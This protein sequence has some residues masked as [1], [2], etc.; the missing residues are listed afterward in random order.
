M[1]CPLAYW[2][3]MIIL[4]GHVQEVNQF[5]CMRPV[6]IHELLIVSEELDPAQSCLFFTVAQEILHVTYIL[7]T[8][9]VLRYL[10]KS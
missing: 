3:C 1:Q 9:N 8:P 4:C 2:N 7:T 5:P 6:F 10:L